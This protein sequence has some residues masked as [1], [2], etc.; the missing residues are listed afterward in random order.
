MSKKSFVP[1]FIAIIFCLFTINTSNAFAQSSQVSENRSVANLIAITSNPNSPS[2]TKSENKSENKSEAKSEAKPE[3]KPESNSLELM[4]EKLKAQQLEIDALKEQLHKMETLLETA[5]NKTSVATSPNLT[6]NLS[7]NLTPNPEPINYPSPIVRPAPIARHAPSEL[8][9]D[10]GHIGAE[11][12]LLIG[13]SQN[14]FKS[15][16]GFFAGGFIDLPLKR[17]KGGKLSYEIMIG[18]QRTVSTQ[19][20]TS[21]VTLLVNGALNAALGN[22]PSVNN[23]LGP[24]PI[25]NKVRER[26]TVLTVVPASFNILFYLLINIIFVLT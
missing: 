17:I 1:V 10:L 11:V 8:L 9:P 5:V 19:Q 25:T 3:A 6:P 18:A 24:L 13:G 7:S 12:G 15:N 14:P 20:T 4:N 26:L 16:E 22:P 21:G 2:E 23:L